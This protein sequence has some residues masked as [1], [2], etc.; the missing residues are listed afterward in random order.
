MRKPILLIVA[1]PLLLWTCK[2]PTEPDL[3]QDL[4]EALT[5]PIKPYRRIVWSPDGAEIFYVSLAP[6]QLRAVA[7]TDKSTRTLETNYQDYLLH[8]VSSDGEYLYYSAQAGG[9]INLYRLGVKG[10]NSERVAKNISVDS[11]RNQPLVAL[12]PDNLHLA[13]MTARNHGDSL[14]LH[15][16]ASGSRKFYTHGRPVCFSPNGSELLVRRGDA[17]RDTLCVLSVSN[18]SVQTIATQLETME[19]WIMEIR[20]TNDGICRLRYKISS[21]AIQSIPSNVERTLGLSDRYRWLGS[22]TWSATGDKFMVWSNECI[23]DLDWS[24][25][26][27]TGY[28]LHLTQLGA[29]QSSLVAHGNVPGNSTGAGS[30]MAFSPDNR[31]VAYVFSERIHVRGIN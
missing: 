25:C 1:F 4:G 15:N 21:Y 30:A 3:S 10:Q 19:S 12:C 23:K 27:T 7:V 26:G 18:G 20:W 16:T 2:S 31:R 6:E 14:F 17:P 5:E 9:M 29:S 28:R 24:S 8:G 11:Y 13:Y 22:I